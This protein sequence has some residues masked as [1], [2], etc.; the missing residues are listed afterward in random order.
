QTLGGDSV[1]SIY[2]ASGALQ[3]RENT[4]TG[5]RTDYLSMGGRTIAKFE[6]QGGVTS[7][8]YLHTDHLGSPVAGTNELS[9]IV[10]QEDHTPFGEKRLNPAAQSG[11]MGFTGHIADTSGLVYMQAR[12]YNPANGRFLS[13]DPV[14]FAEGGVGYFNRYAYVANDP[15]NAWDPNGEEII[16][17][18]RFHATVSVGASISQAP[19]AGHSYGAEQAVGLS[20]GLPSPAD[21]PRLAAQGPLGLAKFEAAAVLAGGAPASDSS[22]TVG[23]VIGAIFDVDI[24]EVGLTLGEVEDRLGQS[25]LAQG[26]VGPVGLEVFSPTDGSLD[27]AGVRASRFGGGMGADIEKTTTGIL[28]DQTGILDEQPLPKED[29]T[30]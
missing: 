25:Y 24:A 18:G 28:W 19:G 9:H 4:S 23:A 21:L 1:C 3:Y 15:V 7:T 27:G 8:T 2:G 5:E 10:W 16:K 26:D 29:Q 12:Y 17:N 6:T 30:K 22:G 11:K 14:G 13:S 20:F